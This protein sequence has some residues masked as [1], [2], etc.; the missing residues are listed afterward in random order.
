M[1]STLKEPST[2]TQT[3]KKPTSTVYTRKQA[4]CTKQHAPQTT[5]DGAPITPSFP[6]PAPPQQHSIRDSQRKRYWAHSSA[7][8]PANDATLVSG[9]WRQG[10]KVALLYP[11][12]G[13]LA[14]PSPRC[15]HATT[16]K[17]R[18]K[19]V[20]ARWLCEAPHH[21]RPSSPSDTAHCW[22]PQSTAL[23]SLYKRSQGQNLSSMHAHGTWHDWPS[24]IQRRHRVPVS[25]NAQSVELHSVPV[26][27]RTSMW[28]VEVMIVV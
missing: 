4:C 1:R 12:P 22:P 10:G 3:A 24:L 16:V 25:R 11:A 6:Y 18:A 5:G 19:A 15:S 17:R 14:W 26:K 23:V 13:P 2:N 7:T 8:G 28:Q 21:E 27:R 9:E 20:L